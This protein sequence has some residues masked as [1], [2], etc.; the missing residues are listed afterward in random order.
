[1]QD[2]SSANDTWLSRRPV[3]ASIV[4]TLVAASLSLGIGLAVMG[5]LA[6]TATVAAGGGDGLQRASASRL[7]WH[8]TWT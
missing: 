1:M 4:A 8:P 7:T 3:Q 2:T 5:A 6:A